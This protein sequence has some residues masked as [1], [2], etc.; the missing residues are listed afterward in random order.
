MSV[1]SS[2]GRPSRIRKIKEATSAMEEA[3]LQLKKVEGKADNDAFR[4]LYYLRNLALKA[5]LSRH[6]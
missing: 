5:P 3:L 4:S 6:P 1:R 2:F